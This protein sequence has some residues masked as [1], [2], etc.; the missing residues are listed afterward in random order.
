[1]FEFLS[2]LLSVHWS[3]KL[4]YT[5]RI[6]CP[7]IRLSKSLLRRLIKEP[8]LLHVV[9]WDQWHG[10]K[11]LRRY[12]LSY[13]KWAWSQNQQCEQGNKSS[14]RLYSTELFQMNVHNPNV[15]IISAMWI[16]YI[17]SE[18]VNYILWAL[19]QSKNI[20]L[21]L[22]HSGWTWKFGFPCRMLSY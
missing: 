14:H 17:T 10:D 6:S 11:Q 15:V 4:L 13:H 19:E 1:M 5:L 9:T 2:G 7:R 16:G 18:Y 3:Y 12:C 21:L 20:L 8:E 22:I